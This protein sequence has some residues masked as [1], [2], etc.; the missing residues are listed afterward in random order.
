VI[1]SQAGGKWQIGFGKGINN[2]K[3]PFALNFAEKLFWLF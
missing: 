3:A 2:N 1:T